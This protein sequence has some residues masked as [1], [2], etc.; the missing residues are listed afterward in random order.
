M[1]LNM[2]NQPKSKYEISSTEPLI[3]ERVKKAEG[4]TKKKFK[5]LEDRFKA[6]EDL[7]S[8]QAKEINKLKTGE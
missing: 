7:I 5:D 2:D 4:G 3:K 6:M 1:K 8:A